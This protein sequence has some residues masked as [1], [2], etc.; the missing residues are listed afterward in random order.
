M[1]R[2]LDSSS[3]IAQIQNVLKGTGKNAVTRLWGEHGP[4]WG[5]SFGDLEELAV[6]MAKVLTQEFLHEALQ[7]QANAEPSAKALLCPTCGRTT[8]PA[9]DATEPRVVQT[10]AGD[11]EWLEPHRT[12]GHCRK[13]FFPSVQGPGY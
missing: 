13:A 1:T 6:Q 8:E 12:C 2:T 5:T 11:A 10:R 3:L 9:A 7:R 4:A